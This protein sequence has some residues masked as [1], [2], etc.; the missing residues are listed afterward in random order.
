MA[1]KLGAQH[2][3]QVDGAL[4]DLGVS[5]H[6]IDQPDRGFAHRLDGVLD[7]RMNKPNEQADDPENEE[8]GTLTA[9][10]L[11][12]TL[13]L[14]GLAEVLAK[15]GDESRATALSME[16]LRARPL[17]SSLELK[18]ALC[19][20]TPARHQT[21]MLSR[22][23]QA[24]RIAVNDELRCLET[25]LSAVHGVTTPGG[26]LVVLSYHSLEDRLVKDLL[27]PGPAKKADKY[28]KYRPSGHESTP[29]PVLWRPVFK[30]PVVP[31]RLELRQNTRSRSAKLRVGERV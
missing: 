27:R 6:Q 16:V 18:T 24:L 1:S 10:H 30:K 8:Q 2:R 29:E 23:F 13:S 28:A 7:M 5:S 4:F 3:Y 14:E 12:N 15:Y 20:I 22:C 25:A 26:R 19:S 11:V 17:V 21:K 9:L 31:S